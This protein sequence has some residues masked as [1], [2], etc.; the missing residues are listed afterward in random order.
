MRVL[1]FNRKGRELLSEL[2]TGDDARLPV[3]TNINKEANDFSEDAGK[4]LALDVKAS[5]IYS[6][7]AGRNIEDYSDHRIKPVIIE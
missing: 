5:D 3:I 7:I 4:M 2:K 6:L 1:G